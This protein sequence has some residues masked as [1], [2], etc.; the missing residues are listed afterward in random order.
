MTTSFDMGPEAGSHGGEVVAEGKL[1]DILKSDSLT[2]KYL[3][4]EMSI[5]IPIERR[6]SK[7]EVTLTGVK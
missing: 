2:A 1:K 7:G 4:N 6:R 3:R 5:P